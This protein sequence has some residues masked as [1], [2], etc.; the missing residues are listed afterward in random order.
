MTDLR[1]HPFDLRHVSEGMAAALTDFWN[2]MEAERVPTDPPSR[3]ESNLG[4]WRNMPDFVTVNGLALF[5]EDGTSL[6]AVGHVSYR[7]AKENQHLAEM[8]IAVL[9]EARRR[10]L[11]DM[12]LRQLTPLVREAGRRS[13]IASSNDTQPS[14][15]AFLETVGARPGLVA[16]MNQLDLTD[17]D[18]PLLEG[19]IERARDRAADYELVY[20]AGPLP[21]EWLEPM[22][23][24]FMIMNTAPRGELDIEDEEVTL[25]QI[26][27][28]EQQLNAGGGTRWKVL[29]RH[30][31]SGEFVGF[32]ELFWHPDNPALLRQWGTG[33][34]PA[35]RD[36]GLGRWLKAANLLRVLDDQPGLRFVRTGNADSNKPM[37]GINYAMGFKPFI[38]ATDWQV[39]IETLEAYLKSKRA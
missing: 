28:W 27:A 38:A 6:Q 19:W 34:S 10:G 13:V 7:K 11:G 17:L 33:V 15:A 3:L 26:K 23:A 24:V 4:E 1:L 30:K 36:R 39:G 35:H 20:L 12:L 25:E 32:T 31:P 2:L 18:R 5:T 9:P 21:D 8:H 37:L 16:H 14:G 29:A 22:R